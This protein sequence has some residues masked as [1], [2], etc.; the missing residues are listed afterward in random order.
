MLSRQDF[1]ILNDLAKNKD[2]VIILDYIDESKKAYSLGQV[3]KF[4]EQNEMIQIKIKDEDSI[5]LF[6]KIINLNDKVTLFFKRR[7]LSFI[8]QFDKKNYDGG[9]IIDLKLPEDINFH[10]RRKNK[11]AILV[12]ACVVKIHKDS[13]AIIKNCYD[14]GVGGLSLL[15]SKSDSLSLNDNEIL[16]SCSLTLS[17]NVNIDLELKHVRSV[18]LAPYQYENYPYGGKRVSFAFNNI[19]KK[20]LEK[21]VAYMD[22]NDAFRI[23]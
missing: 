1:E 9:Q 12:K 20:D 15:L 2:H 3:Q 5:S 8:C 4:D 16:K 23:S 13:K 10:D 7:C 19:S 17:N 6:Q 21:I 22:E 14:L 11:R 18:V